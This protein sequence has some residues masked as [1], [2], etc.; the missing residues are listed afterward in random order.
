MN[1]LILLL[2]ILLQLVASY[3]RSL[4]SLLGFTYSYALDM[5]FFINHV[6]KILQ[7]FKNSLRVG[8]AVLKKIFFVENSEMAA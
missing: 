7:N 3:N 4:L 8:L 1:S 6:K 5:K 2:T